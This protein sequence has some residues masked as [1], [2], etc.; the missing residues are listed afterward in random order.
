M[1]ETLI[2][3]LQHLPWELVFVATVVITF[4][5]HLFPPAPSDVLLV[6]IGTLVGMHIVGFAPILVLSTIGSTIGFSTAYWLGYRYGHG[7]VQRGWLPFITEELLQKVER[8]FARYH[9]WIIVGNRFLAG[10]RAVIAFAAGVVRMPVMRTLVLSTISSLVW[11]TILIYAGSILGT[12]W[13]KADTILSAYGTGITILIV[14]IVVAV[15]L[16]K[17]VQKKRGNG[18]P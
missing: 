2:I 9:D 6:F 16:R 18:K 1:L 11:N 14:G 15:L 8:W 13:K 5:E 10:T 3:F 12:N 4:T 7:V 17:Y